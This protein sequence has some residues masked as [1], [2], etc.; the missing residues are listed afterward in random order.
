[1]KYEFEPDRGADMRLSDEILNTATSATD[2]LIYIRTWPQGLQGDQ[3]KDRLDEIRNMLENGLR[4]LARSLEQL[5]DVQQE[6]APKLEAAL[7][8][9]PA[10]MPACV[11]K[12]ID[13]YGELQ[14]ACDGIVRSSV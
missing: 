4:E 11:L 5:S 12:A 10:T 14:M 1:M 3:Q 13:S 7:E 8:K 2:L 9:H 6:A